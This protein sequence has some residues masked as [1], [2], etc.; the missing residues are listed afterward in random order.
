VNKPTSSP[1]RA[2]SV[3]SANGIV[4]EQTDIFE[5][6]KSFG[7][8]EWRSKAGHIIE[9]HIEDAGW[10]T[11]MTEIEEVSCQL[12][13]KVL[14]EEG[15]TQINL[16][17]CWTNDAHM[18][19][20][21]NTFRG[22]NH[23]TNV[24]SF[25]VDDHDRHKGEANALGDI[26]VARETVFREALESHTEMSHHIIHLLI[27]GMLHLLGYDHI[28]DEDAAEMES[29]ETRLLATVGITNPYEKPYHGKQQEL[30]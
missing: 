19:T 3:S 4:A 22:K 28:N 30:T 9:H 12:F 8:H 15:L 20:L 27:H 17:I 10:R 14:A 7:Y 18:A 5:T 16:S 21:N 6:G 2:G 13:D 1:H 23:P 24:L 29:L 11:F 26:A 25:P